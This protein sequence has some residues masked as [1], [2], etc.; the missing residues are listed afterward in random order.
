M[1]FGYLARRWARRARTTVLALGIV[2]VFVTAKEARIAA[3][4]SPTPQRISCS[5]LA[6][7]GPGENAHVEVTDFVLGW[8]NYET[9]ESSDEWRTVWARARGTTPFH[10]SILVYST[11]IRSSRSFWALSAG[12]AIR[13]TVVQGVGWI[14][15]EIRKALQARHPDLDLDYCWV[16]RHDRPP[17]ERGE[18]ALT[19]AAGV[20]LTVL[21]LRFLWRELFG[22]SD[23]GPAYAPMAARL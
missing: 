22:T 15:A 19:L 9:S 17:K 2:M 11:G 4:A 14:D 12:D 13:G 3:A 21:G 1:I 10:G 16:L 8:A 23:E 5:D 18:L 7:R 6:L 20:A